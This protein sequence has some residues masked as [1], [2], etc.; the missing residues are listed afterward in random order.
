MTVLQ[1]L[2]R[3]CPATRRRVLVC[4][5]LAV[6]PAGAAAPDEAEPKARTVV[7][8]SQYGAGGFHRW[9][10][11][12]EYR[13]LWT[14]PLRVE[15]L[16]LQSYAGGLKPVRAVGH[17]QTQALS[18]KGENGTDY[19]F[20]PL[21]KDPTSLLPVELRQT[22]ARKVLLDQMASGHPGGH[23][24]APGLLQAAGVLHNEP[25]IVLMPDDPALGEFRQTFGNVVGNIEEWTGTRGFAGAAETIDGEEMWKRLRRS[26][27][28]RA[29][30]RAYLEA[31]LVDQLM[32]DWD[33]HRD[34][35]RWARVPGKPRWQPIPE[36]RDQAFVRF[37]G[38]AN[39]IIRPQ[40]PMLVKFGPGYSSLNGLT[41]DGWDVDKKI[42]TDLEKPVWDEVAKELRGEITD[43]QIEA[44]ARRQPPEYFEKD[45]AR[46]IAGLKSRRDNLEEQANRFYRYI[47]R[48]VDVFCTD[49]HERVDARRF[50]NGDLELSVGTASPTGESQGEPYFHRRFEAA[51]VKEVRVYLNGGNDKVVVTGGKHGGVLLRVIAGDGTDVLDDAQGGRTRF[52]SAKS[53]DRVVPGPAS[54]RDR[55]PYKEPPP[56]PRGDWIPAR[57]WGRMTGPLFLMGYGSDYG[58]LIGGALNTTGYGFRKDPWSDRQSLRVLFATRETAFRGAY[59][60]QFRFENSPM[61]VGLFGLASGIEVLRFFG[62]GN[63]SKLEGD[64]STY[65]IEQ[66]R[67]QVEPALIYALG[68]NTDLSLGVIAKY[69]KTDPRENPVLTGEP[70]Y[71]QGHFSQFGLSTRFRWDGTGQLAL[72]RRGAF[73]AGAGLFYPALGDVTDAFGEFHAQGRAYL[74]TRGE[75]GITLSLKAGGQRVFGTYPFFESAFIGGRS[76]FNPLEPGGGSAVRGLP[77]Q[78]YAGDGSLYGG[79]DVYLTLTRAFVA[80]PGQLGLLGF[81]DVGRVFLEGESSDRWHGGY[82]GGIFF[83]SPGRHNLVSFSIARS[84]GNTAY[85]LTAGFAF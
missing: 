14:A 30:S 73:L 29:D 27:E 12:A 34:Q 8:G 46:L 23:V 44:A 56:N 15:V 33:R 36:D 11:G 38:F 68:A 71:G 3:V 50:D 54:H 74:G 22:V 17:G 18:L 62:Q 66:D 84:E 5:L 61:R 26:P 60:G 28:V 1:D 41:F 72:P 10:W 48:V 24:V 35:W 51:V 4:S 31:R 83:V 80:V 45:G 47:N 75:R 65:R 85:Y 13:S 32:G 57:D 79:A 16:D 2:Q 21:L 82:G 81:Y 76:L 6:L 9:L 7:V 20:R 69:S 58:L 49:E 55:R 43:A 64:E 59:L 37:E 78:R 25:A 52:S 77:P 53:Q 63:T 70:V 39:A 67:F 42:L 40:F 19:T